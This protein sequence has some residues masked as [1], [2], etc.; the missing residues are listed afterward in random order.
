MRSSEIVPMICE[1][2]RR[3]W[4]QWQSDLFNSSF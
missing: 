4:T 1:I 3:E 2:D